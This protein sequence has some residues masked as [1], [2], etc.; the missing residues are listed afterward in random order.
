MTEE[1]IFDNPLFK[2]RGRICLRWSG[3]RR[4]GG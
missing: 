4:V 1:L 3:C 2:D